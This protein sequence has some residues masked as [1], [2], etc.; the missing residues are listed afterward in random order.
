[1]GDQLFSQLLK[2]LREEQDLTQEALAEQVGCSVATI[3]AFERG[4]RRPS[5]AMA[6]R[7]GAILAVAPGELPEFLRLARTASGP[8]A[9]QADAEGGVD[10]LPGVA[11]PPVVARPS[12]H[13]RV[14]LPDTALIGRA[15]EVD[16][17][18][19]YL[20]QPTCRLLTII[21]PGG[22][23]KT[24]L[25]RQ[26]AATVAADTQRFPFADGVVFVSLAQV[27]APEHV[28]STIA[29]A[30]GIVLAGERTP[31]EALLD[32][33]RERE[34]LLVLDNLEHLLAAT[35]LL[36][37]ILRE[38]SGVRLLATSRE[39]LRLHAEQVYALQGLAMPASLSR[40]DIDTS[41]AVLL[42]LHRA[43][44]VAGDFALN[45][46]NAAAVAEI[47]RL[48]DGMPL[49][50]EL[51]ATWVRVLSCADIAAE[52]TSDLDF[53]LLSDRDADPRH[54][55]MRAVF[56]HSWRLL[57]IDEGRVLARL[58][59]FRGGCTRAAATAVAGATLPI[60]AALVDK[61]L[62]RRD[63]ADRYTLHELVRQFSA[64]KLAAVP[65][66]LMAVTDQHCAYY[67]TWITTH[68]ATLKSPQQQLAVAAILVEIDNLRAA[69]QHAVGQ[70]QLESLWK[71]TERAS[72][73]W[74]F[75]LRSWYQEAE[76]L[77]R[78]A[79]AALRS[80]PPTT[81]RE[82]ALLG[83]FL[84][85]VGW[86]TFR[87]GR[88][89]EGVQLLE[90]SLTIQRPL[91]Y[92]A[93]LIHALDQL[94]YLSS[95]SGDYERAIALADE[96][97][98]NA[99][100]TGDPWDLA[101]ALYVGAAVFADH[102]PG[103]AY[104][105]F[106]DRLPHI[107]AV[108]DRNLLTMSLSH[109][110][111]IALALG[112]T[113]AAEQAFAEALEYAAEISNG[114][115]EANASN[116]L[117][118]VACAKGAWRDAIAYSLDAVARAR[119]IGDQWTQAKALVTL[120]EAEAGG[121]DQTAARHTFREAIRCCLTARVLPTMIDA[122]LGLATLDLR[123]GRQDQKLVTILALVRDHP[124]TRRPSA[125]RANNLWAELAA[126]SDPYTLAAAE[127]AARQVAP[128]QLSTL[129]NVY[130]G[131]YVA[132]TAPKAEIVRP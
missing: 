80:P 110:G 68:E 114:V 22:I 28:A 84:G 89:A 99:Q 76:A 126:S 67:A 54:R 47:C 118:L 73:S 115:G 109:L 42:F 87:R 5:R 94:A 2:R 43:R 62:L 117:A 56:E 128:D 14:P 24:S 11:G 105:R 52:L 4:R 32:V 13:V 91:H 102:Q 77:H 129:I 90:E 103:V 33:L 7:L 100:Q 71:M 25:A 97:L 122:W 116:G 85:I 96:S 27:M 50:L 92:P 112:E 16:D 78:Q 113:S 49:G 40:A 60:L 65:A 74:F 83:Y 19:R 44:Q 23:G 107:R 98:V 82:Q 12:R 38:T 45:P 30:L 81:E 26:V 59:V 111:E 9:E 130:S 36:V 119:E 53:L 17:V 75:E 55:S 51:A 93:L 125:V 132:P 15:M 79:I 18:C 108:G 29:D 69:W 95:L 120:A 10:D 1:M 124:A 64:E 48:L 131:Q 6:D 20:H 8:S 39:R 58:S 106:A 31:D 46:E 61:S 88:P 57:T 127:D 70:R 66:E 86:Y 3:S 37:S 41:A 35:P 104:A 123:S 121:G 63:T 34:L 72:L 21:G 101:H